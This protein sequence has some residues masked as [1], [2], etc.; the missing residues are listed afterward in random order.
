MRR[1]PRNT[2]ACDAD[3]SGPGETRIPEQRSKPPAADSCAEILRRLMSQPVRLGFPSTTGP[4][5]APRNGT[6]DR[7]SLRTKAT[8]LQTSKDD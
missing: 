2:S 5:S 7:G 4:I 3:S 6:V 1:V 8:A